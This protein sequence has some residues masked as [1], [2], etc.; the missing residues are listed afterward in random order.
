MTTWQSIITSAASTRRN[1]TDAGTLEAAVSPAGQQAS[2]KQLLFL[3]FP[4][5]LVPVPLESPNQF[6]TAS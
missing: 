6:S 5:L 4:S 3:C 1:F 2:L